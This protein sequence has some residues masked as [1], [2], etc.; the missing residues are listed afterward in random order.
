MCREVKREQSRDYRER[1]REARRE[2]N[3]DYYDRNRDTMC[4]QKRD[5]YDEN[6]EY[7]LRQGKKRR[8]RLGSIPSPRNYSRWTPADDAIAC[9]DGITMVEMC[10]LLGRSY[11]A[12]H[13]RR[14]RLRGNGI[15]VDREG[16]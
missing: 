10:Y 8:Q 12:V 7:H 13:N 6:R 11:Q 15:D 4:E 2:Y 16:D 14:T 1:N 9:R 3:R 5:Y